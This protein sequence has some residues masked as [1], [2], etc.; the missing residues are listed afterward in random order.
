MHF[1]V[2]GHTGFKGSWLILMLKALGHKVSGYA[3]DPVR[4]GLFD[5]AGL[6]SLLE[7]H[8]LADI[9]DFETLNEAL[10]EV[11]PD[12]AIHMAAQ[13]LVLQ[14]YADPIETYTVNVNGTLNFLRG[15]QGLEDR[16]LSLVVTTDKVYRDQ[17]TG[18]YS[19]T[20]PLGGKD[21]YST[22]KA[23]ADI[24][25]QSW[26]NGALN[27]KVLVARAGNVIGAFDKSPDRLIP[28]IVTSLQTKIPIAVRNP[29]AVRPW[30]HVMDCLV[31]YLMM[32]FRALEDP[33]MPRVMNFGPN[34]SERI[35]VME[36]LQ[37]AQKDFPELD[38]V[39]EPDDANSLETEFLTLN[40]SL[41]NS[42]L[43]WSPKL[44]VT[45][46]VRLSLAE[47]TESD[48]RTLVSVQIQSFL[49]RLDD[50]T[51]SQIS[52]KV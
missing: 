39:V 31:G 23:M 40:A 38:I 28:D 42:L 1:F 11:R 36:L 18:D 8:F 3:L 33:G 50:Q 20:A 32:I 29:S 27:N 47:L 43:G 49:D 44:S 19:E 37:I 5:A 51:V 6:E 45:E 46:A 7:R 35:S 10:S 16:P 15:T 26:E 14:S 41:A 52:R 13:P 34:D 24:L 21:P 48:A 25:A 30:Q 9:R 2:T 12:V 17:G 4:G 22:S